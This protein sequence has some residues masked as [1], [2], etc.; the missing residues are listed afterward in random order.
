MDVPSIP[1]IGTIVNDDKATFTIANSTVIEGDVL[2]FTVLLSNAVQG[3]VTMAY[4][5]SDDT[6]KASDS[7]YVNSPTPLVFTGVQG[8]LLTIHVPTLSDTK[9]EIDETM[10]VLPGVVTPGGAGVDPAD[11]SFVNPFSIGTI[12]NDDY[13]ELLVSPATT[14][15]GGALSFVVQLSAAVQDGLTVQYATQNGTASTVDGDY[16]AASGTLTFAGT[17]GETKTVTVSTLNDTKF[18]SAETLS[19]RLNNIRLRIPNISYGGFITTPAAGGLGTILDDDTA[20]ITVTDVSI[21]EGGN[22][23]FSVRL[24]AAVQGGVLVDYATSDVSATLADADYGQVT[25]TLQFQ[26]NA[27]EVKTVAVPTLADTA[28]EANEQLNLLLSNARP[29]DP[30]LAGGGLTVAKSIGLG[31]I[32]N[33]DTSSV[34]ISDVSVTEGG[35]LQFEVRLGN[36]VQGGLTVAYQSSDGTA[37]ATDD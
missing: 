21:T 25:G 2:A 13:A 37:V 32:L 8:E 30:A 5:L 1:A 12:E 22:L 35:N 19:L 18:E 7:D 15:E 33:D 24:S 14:T 17:S 6:A 26:G 9:V 23:Q 16:A 28:L 10:K 20:D 29:V 34:S 31:T 4:T 27:G 36:A 3:G 11:F